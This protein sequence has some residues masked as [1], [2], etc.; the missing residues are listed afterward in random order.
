MFNENSLK[1]VRFLPEGTSLGMI[2][3]VSI[4][5]LFLL[6]LLVILIAVVFSLKRRKADPNADETSSQ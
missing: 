3:G 5:S 6:L 1:I 2:I 4:A